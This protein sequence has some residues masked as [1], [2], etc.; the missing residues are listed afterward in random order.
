M[1]AKKNARNGEVTVPTRTH[2]DTHAHSGAG[3]IDTSSTGGRPLAAAARENKWA[4]SQTIHGERERTVDTNYQPNDDI[5]DAG[6]APTVSSKGNLLVH[7]SNY[8]ERA[9]ASRDTES[10]CSAGQ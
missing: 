2:T 10:S 3:A 4:T 6:P 9:N 8:K 7:Q 5:G 1:S